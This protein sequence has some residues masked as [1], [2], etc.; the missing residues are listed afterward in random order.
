VEPE[1]ENDVEEWLNEAARASARSN[2]RS[3]G[4]HSQTGI[5]H[6]TLCAVQDDPGSHVIS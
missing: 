3:S 2:T 6:E 4:D 1:P 5:Q